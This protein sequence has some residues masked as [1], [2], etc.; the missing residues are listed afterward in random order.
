MFLPNLHRT[1]NRAPVSTEHNILQDDQRHIHL[2]LPLK[3]LSMFTLLIPCLFTQRDW[4]FLFLSWPPIYGV[5]TCTNKAMMRM[6]FFLP[7]A[8]STLLN[9]VEFQWIRWSCERY[10]LLIEGSA[11]NRTLKSTYS[12]K[13]CNNYEGDYFMPVPCPVIRLVCKQLEEPPHGNRLT[14]MVT[15]WEQALIFLLVYRRPGVGEQVPETGDLNRWLD[16][17][18]FIGAWHCCFWHELRL[19]FIICFVAKKR[20]VAC[21]M[22]ILGPVNRGT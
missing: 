7:M 20:L 8:S 22:W 10:L 19:P 6:P 12:Y 16:D 15:H 14:N 4:G 3:K 17:K 2:T 13:V 21:A 1:K 18:S 11:I 9:N 5:D